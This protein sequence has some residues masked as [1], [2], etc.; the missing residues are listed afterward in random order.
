MPRTSIF[1]NKT[2]V[3]ITIISFVLI[4]IICIYYFFAF[5]SFDKST[6]KNIHDDI[7]QGLSGL[8]SV[9]IAVIIFRIQ[10]LENRNH[11]LEQSTLNYISQTMGYTYPEWTK[12][13]E[14]DIKKSTLTDRYYAGV[15]QQSLDIVL[16]EKKR[17]QERLEE[18]LDLHV[19]TKRTIQRIRHD[20]FFCAFFLI[21]PLLLSLILLMVYDVLDLF[22][23]F[24]SA[25]VVVVISSV[26]IML[27]I[28]MV[29][30]AV[31]QEP[32]R[33]N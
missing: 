24:F 15:P 20:V 26:G 31:V 33:Q 3:V 4:G 28:K 18:A 22:W 10:S 11:S 12:S 8:G 9:A 27:L 32:V 6:A 5:D 7:I 30:G 29:L 21:L 17:R 25:S 16:Q 1:R 19:K 23:T 14:N 13:L 2:L